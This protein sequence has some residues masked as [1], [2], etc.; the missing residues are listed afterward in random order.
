MKNC[1]LVV[2]QPQ[3]KSNTV[4]DGTRKGVLQSFLWPVPSLKQSEDPLLVSPIRIQLSMPSLPA[5]PSLVAGGTMDNKSQ[6]DSKSHGKQFLEM[7]QCLIIF[8]VCVCSLQC[9]AGDLFSK[10]PS[11]SAFR[12]SAWQHTNWASQRTKGAV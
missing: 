8:K 1:T 6:Q 10:K 3:Q 5:S 9:V 4:Q 11:K 2:C 7:L 12:S